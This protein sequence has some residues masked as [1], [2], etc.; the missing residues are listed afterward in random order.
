[1]CIWWRIQCNHRHTCW[2]FILR[3]FAT[4][5]LCFNL[6]VKDTVVAGGNGRAAD[7]ATGF[8][9]IDNLPVNNLQQACDRTRRVFTEMQGEFSDGP[10]G[11]NYTQVNVRFSDTLIEVILYSLILFTHSIIHKQIFLILFLLFYARIHIVN[12]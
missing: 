12:G 7:I 5:A 6:I 9:T 10:V 1:M 4:V 3:S 2:I 8:P 11:Y